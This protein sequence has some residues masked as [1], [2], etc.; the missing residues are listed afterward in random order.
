M[1]ILF[2]GFMMILAMYL[3]LVFNM[4]SFE[5]FLTCIT[6]GAILGLVL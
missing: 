5:I 1:R 4:N 2:V 6:F 3:S